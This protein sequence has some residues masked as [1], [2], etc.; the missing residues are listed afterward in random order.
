MTQSRVEQVRPH[1][2]EN[3]ISTH[4]G[5]V[6]DVREP[7]EWLMGTLPGAEK[8]SLGRLPTSLDD[9]D[10]S[11]PLLIVCR[12]GNRSQLAA[13]FLAA[14]GFTRVANLVGG[15]VALGRAA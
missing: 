10:R 8:L 15:M 1:E 4:Q 11:V 6:L 3:W 13:R 7:A 9:L 14:N 5:A 2:W 12:S